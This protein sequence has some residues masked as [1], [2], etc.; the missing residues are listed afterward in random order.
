MDACIDIGN[1]RVKLALFDEDSL[2]Q[3]LYQEKLSQSWIDDVRSKYS[4]HSAIV[5]TVRK[6][7]DLVM[8]SLGDIS[9]TFLLSHDLPIPIVNDYRTP[10]KLGKDRLAAAVGAFAIFPSKN[11]LIIDA[12]TC[13]TA[14]ILDS[15]GHFLGGSILPGIKMRLEAMHR[16]THALPL[17]EWKDHPDMIGQSTE[18][19][20]LVGGVNACVLEIDGII[21][22]FK[23]IY[24]DLKVLF[25][26]GDTAFFE[27]HLK[28]EIFA[29]PDLVLTGLHK[30]L[31]FNAKR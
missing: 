1:T 11:C 12:G 17:V 21:D 27:K 14:D 8:E 20:L 31:K 23:S 30:I 10:K 25:T 3:V 9:Q 2:Q 15:K 22:H 16:F 4:I 13:I 19:S 5:S 7:E 29:A 26:G 24:Q 6:N 18:E 28:N